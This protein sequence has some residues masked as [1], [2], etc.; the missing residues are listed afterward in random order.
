MTSE[1]L[2][3]LRTLSLQTAIVLAVLVS[4]LWHSLHVTVLLVS[5]LEQQNSTLGKDSLPKIP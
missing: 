2:G 1:V 3:S 4:V 5:G